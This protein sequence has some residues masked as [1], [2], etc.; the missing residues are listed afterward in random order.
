MR[1]FVAGATGALGMQLVPRLVAA[2]H[3][4]TGM[5][6]TPRA[7]RTKIRKLGARRSSPTRSTPTRSA[8][9]WPRRCPTSSCTSSPRSRARSTCAARAHFAETNRL[10]TE[11]TDHLLAAA[12][13]EASRASSP[14]ATPRLDARRGAPGH[15]RGGPG[16]RRRRP[17]HAHDARRD[18]PPR[19]RGHSARIRPRASSCA[20]GGS[21]APAR[22]SPPGATTSSGPQAPVPDRRRRRRRLVVHPHRGRRGRDRVAPSGR[23]RHLHVVDDAPARVAD[24][25]PAV[26]EPLGAKRRAACRAGRAAWS[27]AQPA[28]A[29]MTECVAR[30]TRR[31][32]G[33]WAGPG[34]S[35]LARRASREAA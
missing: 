29:M 2:G 17:A 7:S 12:R 3:E 33:S 15:D 16:R 5:T 4:V 30:R 18:P 13:P 11:A 21:T 6:R 9:P 22:R 23:P 34:A 8:T 1:V 25:L 14:R 32:S 20:M 28:T 27:P 31:P 10:R 26:A 35:E 19:G 24:W